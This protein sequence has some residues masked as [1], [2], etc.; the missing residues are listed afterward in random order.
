MVQ[1]LNKKGN[2]K[3][4]NLRQSDNISNINTTHTYKEHRV[5]VINIVSS[6]LYYIINQWN[7]D[8]FSSRDYNKISQAKSKT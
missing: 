1:R 2:W 4:H 7:S 6:F 5:K 8:L 3:D